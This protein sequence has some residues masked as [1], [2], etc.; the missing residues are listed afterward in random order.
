MAML[1][2]VL[3]WTMVAV[4]GLTFAGF[5]FG[6]AAVL[7]LIERAMHRSQ[8]LARPLTIPLD[9]RLRFIPRFLA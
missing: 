1:N 8:T 9:R 4:C 3:A 6:F 5:L 7:T 2:V